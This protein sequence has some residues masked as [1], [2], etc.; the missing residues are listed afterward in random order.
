MNAL[1]IL[2]VTGDA[3]IMLKILYWILLILWAIGAI[4]WAAHPTWV[5]GS[6][7]VLIILFAILGW[8][9]FGF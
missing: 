2:A 1:T 8:V 7:I 6:G 3:P 5:R 4:G 9:I